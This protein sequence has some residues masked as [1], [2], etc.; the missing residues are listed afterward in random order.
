MV[1]FALAFDAT[2]T[3]Y[4]PPHHS[5]PHPTPIPSRA[6]TPRICDGTRV[7]TPATRGPQVAAP[8]DPRGPPGEPCGLSGT[9][10]SRGLPFGTR[11]RRFVSRAI[12]WLPAPPLIGAS[13]SHLD[14]L[15]AGNGSPPLLA[16]RHYRSARTSWISSPPL[17]SPS[18]RRSLPR[19]GRIDPRPVA[20][21]RRSDN[22]PGRSTRG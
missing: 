9:S 6:F 12:L 15:K 16:L 20:D 7:P 8:G 4:S 5:P 22:A 13:R 19:E 18:R 14:P 11:V 1:R 10:R 21:R 3:H 17:G 2:S